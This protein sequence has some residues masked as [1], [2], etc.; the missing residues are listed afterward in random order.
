MI[1]ISPAAIQEI[2]RL[3]A[4]FANPEALFRL[5]V[6]PG[7]CSGLIYKLNFDPPTQSDRLYESNGINI[8]IDPSSVE[9]LNGLT[10]DYSEDLM[11]GAFRFHNPN[12][13]TFCGCGNSFATTA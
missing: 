8:V 9:H 2:R 10:L 13:L 11:G 12:A 7:G 6:E 1:T 5:Q 3:K 4:K